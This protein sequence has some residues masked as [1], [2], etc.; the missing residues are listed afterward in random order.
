MD[1]ASVRRGR[2]TLHLAF[3]ESLAILVA[4]GLMNASYGLIFNGDHARSVEAHSELVAGIGATSGMVI[5]QTVD[6]SGGASVKNL[7][8]DETEAIRN[9]KTSALVR[10][11]L[12]LGAILSGANA[13]QLIALT[14][15]A[16]LLGDAYQTS[17]DLLDLDEDVALTFNS[18]RSA[19]LTIERGRRTATRR[20]NASTHK[21]KQILTEQFGETTP[22]RLLCEMA[23]YIAARSDIANV[24]SD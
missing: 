11:A 5:G 15:F 13:A 8:T 20:I 19:T 16:E 22:A 9:L 21:A 17:D 4:L 24:S 18:G 3:S 10:L 1:N 2:A 7:T 23:E 6:L 14:K 12:R